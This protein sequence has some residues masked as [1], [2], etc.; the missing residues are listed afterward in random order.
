M[1]FFDPAPLS[2]GDWAQSPSCPQSVGQAWGHQ[3]HLAHSFPIQAAPGVSASLICSG[4]VTW[5]IG[6]GVIVAVTVVGAVYVVK[7]IK[8]VQGQGWTRGHGIRV[9]GVK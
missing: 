9:Y 7:Y 1:F 5:L 3:G 8:T 4:P 2:N 6:A